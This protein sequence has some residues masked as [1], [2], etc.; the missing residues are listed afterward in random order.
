MHTTVPCLAPSGFLTGNIPGSL[1][2]GW[3]GSSRSSDS[4]PCPTSEEIATLTLGH[5]SCVISRENLHL[6]LTSHQGTVKE[7]SA[8]K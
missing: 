4:N 7:K 8:K 1:S 5:V 6:P 2:L 3:K